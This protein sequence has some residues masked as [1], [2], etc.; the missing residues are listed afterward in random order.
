MLQSIVCAFTE[1]C[2]VYVPNVC[3]CVTN[4]TFL[5]NYLVQNGILIGDPHTVDSFLLQ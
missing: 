4:L 1:K 3:I 5:T 2:K